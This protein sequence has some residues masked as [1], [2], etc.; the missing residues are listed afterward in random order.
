MNKPNLRTDGTPRVRANHW[1]TSA[2]S[3]KLSFIL[4]LKQLLID[5][6]SIDMYSGVFLGEMCSDRYKIMVVDKKYRKAL[7]LLCLTSRSSP[8]AANSS[9]VLRLDS[10]LRELRK[11]P[12][13]H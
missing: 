10:I 6:S 11:L 8:N 13:L 5:R 9:D 7:A 3:S 1:T 2:K 4:I 12:E